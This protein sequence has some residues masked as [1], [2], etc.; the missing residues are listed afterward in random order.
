[1]LNLRKAPVVALNLRNGRVALSILG[2]YSHGNSIRAGTHGTPTIVTSAG[3][4]PALIHNCSPAV[5][6]M[7]SFWSGQ[8]GHGLKNGTVPT[9]S[10]LLAGL[11]ELGAP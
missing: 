9:K 3:G 5:G 10:G 8:S 6:T 2:V 1:M 11:H 7:H 4:R